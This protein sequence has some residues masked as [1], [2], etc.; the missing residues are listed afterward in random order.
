MDSK[1]L[2]PDKFVLVAPAVWKK[3]KWSDILESEKIIDFDENDSTTMDYL[4]KYRLLGQAKPTR[5][6]VNSNEAI[7]RL[8]SGAIGYG[9]LTEE[10]AKP[11]LD[12]GRLITL[13]NGAVMEAPHALV[14]YPRPQMPGYFRELVKSIY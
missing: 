14:W 1:R 2:K 7:I 13:N 4:K 12:S 6:F 11:H 8:F 10:V 3:R 5:I 9:T